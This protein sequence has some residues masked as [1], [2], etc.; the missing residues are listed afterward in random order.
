M[1]G[2]TIRVLLAEDH[3][4][5]RKGLRAILED[6]PGILVVGEAEDGRQAVQ[7]AAQLKPDVVLM[8][9]SMPGLNGLEATVQLVKQAPSVKVLVL[10]RHTEREYVIRM[11]EAGAAGY[12]LKKTAPEELVIAIQTVQ[13]GEFYIDPEFAE[14]L[15]DS[16]ADRPIRERG[17]L[18]HRLTP[19][20]REVL[21]LIVEGRA[22]REIAALLHVSVK[23][24]EN[25]RTRLLETLN[26]HSTAELTQFA[27]RLG[28]INLD[29]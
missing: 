24:V 6:Q 29:E 13:R 21:Q 16:G 20:Q 8:D 26:L 1:S 23:T 2:A 11:L 12:L 9:M 17:D 27:I 28:I 14:Y 15:P 22:N 3:T 7:R 18:Y 19:R 25:H 4:I 10:S 5:V